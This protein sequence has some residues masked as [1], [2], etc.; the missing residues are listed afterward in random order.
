MTSLVRMGILLLLLLRL[1]LLLLV[2]TLLMHLHLQPSERDEAEV[3]A[4]LSAHL[5]RMHRVLLCVLTSAG[6]EE[7]GVEVGLVDGVV[8]LWLTERCIATLL[9]RNRNMRERKQRSSGLWRW[10]SV[11]RK[12]GGIAMN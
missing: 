4:I 8:L 1:S 5:L 11:M 3:A 2:E 7:V 12:M 10:R 6:Q 9:L